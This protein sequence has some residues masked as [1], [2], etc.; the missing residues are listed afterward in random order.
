MRKN[1][2]YLPEFCFPLRTKERYLKG[3]W[4]GYVIALSAYRRVNLSIWFGMNLCGLW[5]LLYS[6]LVLLRLWKGSFSLFSFANRVEK[7]NVHLLCKQSFSFAFFKKRKFKYRGD[8]SANNSQKI[9]INK[10]TWSEVSKMLKTKKAYFTD[11]SLSFVKSQG[12]IT[13]NKRYFP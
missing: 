13:L 10:G 12:I 3:F 8:F 9:W 2:P 1:V 6:F 11:F 7:F 5:R 4:F